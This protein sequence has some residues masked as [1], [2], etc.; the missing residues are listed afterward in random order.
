M[1]NVR[2]NDNQPTDLAHHSHQCRTRPRTCQ[3]STSK[4]RCWMQLSLNRP[5][6]DLSRGRFH[7]SRRSYPYPPTWTYRH[8]S[9][10]PSCF[11]EVRNYPSLILSSTCSRS[12]LFPRL[13]SC[14]DA[15]SCSPNQVS[16]RQ[17]RKRPGTPGS[18]PNWKRMLCLA[19][20]L[21]LER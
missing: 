2:R 18:E 1:T 12:V 17:H 8:S 10:R 4:Q 21:V 6:L 19:K 20:Y 15:D 9:P 13:I 7:P 11:P 5:H 14:V 16:E 3:N